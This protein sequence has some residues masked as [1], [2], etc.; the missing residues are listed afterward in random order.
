MSKSVFNIQA[1]VYQH[2]A[3]TACSYY[4]QSGSNIL[5]R[6]LSISLG[7]EVTRVQRK[8]RNLQHRVAGQMVGKYVVSEVSPLKQHHPFN[9]R[10][11]IW[12]LP[13]HPTFLGYGTLGITGESG[14]VDGDTGDLVVFYSTDNYK[15]VVVFYLAGMGNPNDMEEAVKYIQTKVD[16][17][18]YK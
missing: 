8:G 6:R 7:S 9:I 4:R 14:R 2:K 3:D 13:S 15:N 5:P 12:E 11:Q 1:A 18:E 16:S 10:T 17:G